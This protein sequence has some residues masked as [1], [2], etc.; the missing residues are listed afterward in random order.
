MSFLYPYMLF[1]LAALAIPIIIHLF[2]FRRHKPVLFSN[3]ALLKQI[4]QENAKTKKLK[5]LVV[6][7]A[8]MTMIAALVIAFSY[9]YR[10]SQNITSIDDD[11]LVAIYIDNSLS[12]QCYADNAPLLEKA[13]TSARDLVKNMRPSQRFVLLT[14][15][16][17]PDDE[18]PMNKDEMLLRIDA[19][20]SESVPSSFTSVYQNIHL[21][22]DRFGF[23]SASLFLF[24]DFQY[25]FLNESTP[26][27]SPDSL[28]NV[29]LCPLLSDYQHNVYVDSVWLSSPFLQ[30]GLL[31]DVNALIVND[32]DKAIDG[33]PVSL[34]VDG[35][36]SS[37]STV[38]V[39]AHGQSVASLQLS[40]DYP[41][42]NTACVSISDA[43][44]SFDDEFFLTLNVQPK[45]NVVEIIDNDEPDIPI[46][47]LF[48]G[49]PMF[50]YLGVDPYHLDQQSLNDVQLII[51][52][53]DANVGESLWQ[54]ILS[55]ANNG[56]SV[57]L[58]P[59]ESDYQNDTL[60]A[61]VISSNH[62][63]FDDVFLKIPDNAEYPIVYRY[64]KIKKLEN[65]AL[66]LIGLQNGMP[67]LTVSD[68]G[69]GSVFS[70]SVR[71]NDSWGNLS[72][73]AL[74]V[75]LMYKIAMYGA[76]QT[77]LYFTIGKDKSLL[78]NDLSAFSDGGVSV[79]EP[80]SS[81]EMIPSV[82]M[83][84]N[85]VVL[86]LDEDLPTSGFYD[87][88]KG[89]VVLM[90]TAWNDSREESRMSFLDAEKALKILKDNGLNVASVIKD[91]DFSSDAVID[92][93]TG[94]SSLW[95]YFIII[96]LLAMLIE[97]LVLRFWK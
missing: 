7:A 46:R 81:F 21:I 57:L 91:D 47:T 77:K 88:C 36:I 6:L 82:E 75:P 90:K 22:A 67:L 51:V 65:N 33:L 29:I 95:K 55:C 41:S 15:S 71:F 61:N 64:S 53:G 26:L 1:G 18:Y 2:N 68:V 31:N 74:F 8:R 80:N 13:R 62:R 3:T 79:R 93:L 58:L 94:K 66:T 49:D 72:D 83:R 14:N 4:E 85:K 11:S 35:T 54:T 37:I 12:M 63:F 50:N 60:Y 86:F 32:S 19:M 17:I 97:I 87:V 56:S 34:S 10:P 92:S 20:P 76:R 9:P 27:P 78:L 84:N 23:H 24:S 44:V 59:K 28:L 45:I 40:I 38:N 25:S 48:D 52:N 43:P 39:P 5:Y 70:F 73:N 42:E 16:R 69:M 96:S 30:P 89:D